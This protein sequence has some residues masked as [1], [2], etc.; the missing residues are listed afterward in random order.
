MAQAKAESL[1]WTEETKEWNITTRINARGLFE[2]ERPVRPAGVSQRAFYGGNFY[3]L[4]NEKALCLYPGC[5][6]THAVPGGS[7][8]NPIKHWQ[9]VHG[10]LTAE[11]DHKGA[12]EDT[13]TQTDVSHFSIAAGQAKAVTATKETQNGSQLRPESPAEVRSK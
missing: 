12:P 6:T 10:Y 8:S 3:E 9:R 4:A 7:M 1:F 5:N 11:A 2:V 13:A